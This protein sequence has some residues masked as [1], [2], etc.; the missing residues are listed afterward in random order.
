MKRAF[1]TLK[2][3]HNGSRVS[4]PDFVIRIKEPAGMYVMYVC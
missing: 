3:R 2:P 4:G 1:N